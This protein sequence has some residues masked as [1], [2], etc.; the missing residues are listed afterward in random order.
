MGGVLVGV[1]TGGAIG[2]GAPPAT[3]GTSG[4]GGFGVEGIGTGSGGAGGG[5]AAGGAGAGTG[6]DGPAP[7]GGGGV[8]PGGNSAGGEM[9]GA[10]GAG[11]AG[12]GGAA[13]PDT[14]NYN[15]ESSNQA[16]G[17]GTG[18]PGTFTSV[19]RSTTQHFAGQASL[20]AS[21]S[22]P[23]AAT[24]FI[25]EVNPPVPAIPAGA[26]VTFHLYVPRSAALTAVVAYAL[27]AGNNYR[28]DNTFVAPASLARD[29]WTTVRVTV[30]ADATTILRIGVRFEFSGA[31]TGTVYLDSIDW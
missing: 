24:H 2:A 5:S 28:F 10:A 14:A 16:W 21:L 27:E 22:A 17:M 13:A 31:W 18:S 9:G 1:D 6:G 3:G 8:A 29:A 15:F 25:L 7:V 12:M 19:G 23:A 11:V 20:A 26:V 4:S 30:P